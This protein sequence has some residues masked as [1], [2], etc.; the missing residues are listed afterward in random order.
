M[1]KRII[2][3]FLVLLL[4]EGFS[5]E[6]KK[7]ELKFKPLKFNITEDGS[8]WVRF[9]LWNQVQ[10]NSSNLDSEARFTLKPNIRRSR[11]LLLG[12]VTKNMFTYIHLGVNNV[13][14]SSIGGSS[15][16]DGTQYFLHDAAIEYKFSEAFAVGGGL[17]YWN[18]MA[19]LASWAGLTSMTYDI[20]NPVIFVPGL[21]T[22]D[23]FARHV[24]LYV[25]G[26]INKLEYRVAFND[27]SLTGARENIT[28]L[29]ENNAVYGAWD[30]HD[31]GR[32]I[33]A[34]NIKYNFLGAEGNLLPYVVGTYLGKKKTLS[35]SF[36]FFNHAN[37]VLTLNNNANPVLIGDDTATIVSKTSTD[38]VFNYS[39]D[40]NY[41]TPLGNQGGALTAYGAYLSYDYGENGSSLSGATGT[42]FYGHLGYLIPKTKLQPYVAYQKR[43]WDDDT[44]VGSQRSGSTTNLGAN[45]YFVG[46]NLKLTFEY[47]KSN[48][49]A[50]Q[51]VS[52][53]RL[54][55]HMFL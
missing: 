45:Y 14:T 3:S 31:K 25:K 34:G 36:G 44:F 7:L 27:P 46:H 12:Q 29:A 13:N 51:D 39:L 19:R 54:Q 16:S 17:H 48:F 8:Q 43:N 10:M 53:L 40:V 26:K 28:N 11:L 2:L 24:G 41:D 20:P 6:K 1:K 21:N 33:I 15:G 52:Q 49:D 47:L 22:T 23:Q 32:T 4:L 37:G 38:D 5:Q 42:A 18:G 35:A 50:G 9:I 30:Y 55:L